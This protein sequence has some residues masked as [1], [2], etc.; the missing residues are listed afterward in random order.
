LTVNDTGKATI[1]VRYKKS[2]EHVNK[3]N[4]DTRATTRFILKKI[5]QIPEKAKLC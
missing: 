5:K 4:K 3:Q 2:F 1:A